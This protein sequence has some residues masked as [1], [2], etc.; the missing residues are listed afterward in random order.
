MSEVMFMWMDC[1]NGN[2]IEGLES[3]MSKIFV[4]VLK[5][6]K[7]RDSSI[8]GVIIVVNFLVIC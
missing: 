7:V 4:P 3:L 2:M 6:Q 8:N 1:S 5:S